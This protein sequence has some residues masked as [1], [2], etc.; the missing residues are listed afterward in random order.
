[1]RQDKSKQSCALI[2]GACCRRLNG[3][4][5]LA[6][7]CWPTSVAG[8]MNI[9][10]GGFFT[11]KNSISTSGMIMGMVSGQWET[12]LQCNVVSLGWGHNQKDSWHIQA[13]MCWYCF[14]RVQKQFPPEQHFDENFK[15][16]EFSSRWFNWQR[17]TIG[18]GKGLVWN[19]RMCV[20]PTKINS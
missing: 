6:T 13:W 10:K 3:S 15:L 1:M 16:F 12:T 8:E 18:S 14:C 5:V 2:Y 20:L 11:L 19:R 4:R 7:T 9:S 17:I